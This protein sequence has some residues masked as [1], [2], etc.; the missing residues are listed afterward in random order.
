MENRWSDADAAAL[1]P[2]SLLVYMSRLV[3]SDP[4]LVLWGGGNT[5]L[6]TTEQDF[7]GR[8]VRVL[9][10]K[11]SG[12]DLKSVR[13]RDFPGVRLDDVLPLIER[14]EMGDQ[15]MV[16]YLAHTLMEPGSARPSVETL[17]HAFIPAQAVVHSHADAILSFADNVN[18]VQLIRDALGEDVILIPYRLSGFL[19]AKEVGLAVRAHPN[20]GA[21]VLLRHGLVTWAETPEEAYRRHIEVINAAETYIARRVAEKRELRPASGIHI[22]PHIRRRVAAQVAPVLRGLVSPAHA[23]LQFDDADPVLRFVNW[24]E[25]ERV[26]QI[27]AITPDHL[28][29]TKRLPLIV[30][31]ADPTDVGALKEALRSAVAAYKEEYLAYVAKYNREGHAVRDPGPRIILVPGLGMWTAGR[32]AKQAIIPMELYRHT[33]SVIEDAEAIGRYISIPEEEAYKVEYWPPELYRMTLAPSEKE[34]TGRVALVTGGARGIGAAVVRKLAAEGAHVV[35]ADID[36]QEAD[37]LAAEMNRGD[38]SRAIAVQMDVTDEGSVQKGVAE[39]VLAFGGI[40]ILFSNAGIAPTG[41]IMDLALYDWERSFSI[42]ATG[43]F[44]VAREVVR[45]L[46]EQRLGGSVIFNCTK[47]VLVPGKEIGAYSCAKAAE[48]QLARILAIEH[49]TDKVRVNIVNPD[50]VFTDLWS[51][52]VREDRAKTYGIPVERLE[53]HYRDRT[54]LKESVRAE[55]VAETVFFL[56]S[57]RS[58]KTT[59]CIFTID[60][61]ARDAF[62]R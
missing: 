59:G 8:Q 55:D 34:L 52:K 50:A 19:M 60:A 37:A 9:R 39:A 49:G 56:A 45:I 2:L 16:D 24:D 31:V 35:I 25:L 18:E 38:A 41:A 22:E 44:L 36:A 40:D 43:H 54:L 5:S 23:V 13:E 29:S 26:S 17:M 10:V 53:E 1:P 32:N 27:G 6:K 51:P 42:N 58:S 3:G 47:N 62:P 7:R 28:F 61:G 20:A 48:A 46:K 33:I 14:D 12:S 30:R 21:V 11:G 15:E 4:S 57:D